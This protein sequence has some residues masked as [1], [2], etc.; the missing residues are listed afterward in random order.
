MPDLVDHVPVALHRHHCAKHKSLVAQGV[1]E[2]DSHRLPRGLQQKSEQTGLATEEPAQ[3]LRNR[4]SILTVDDGPKYL[5]VDD[6]PKRRARFWWQ[7]GQNRRSSRVV[8]TVDPVPTLN[9]SL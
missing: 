8:R 3:H 4:E 7:L 1:L 5:C 9:G 2:E 6:S